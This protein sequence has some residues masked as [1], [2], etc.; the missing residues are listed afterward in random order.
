MA[1]DDRTDVLVVDAGASGAAVAWRLAGAGIDVVCLEQGDWVGARAYPHWRA[2]W[3]LH[4]QWVRVAQPRIAGRKVG[5]VVGAG[6]PSR[7]W[8]GG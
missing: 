1:A 3:E 2:D 7:R 6:G 5:E 4:R 8:P